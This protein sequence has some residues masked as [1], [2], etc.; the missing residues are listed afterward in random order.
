MVGGIRYDCWFIGTHFIT[1][2][3]PVILH[4]V[5]KDCLLLQ[6]GFGRGGG[7][8]GRGSSSG[9]GSRGGSMT[10]ETGHW[11]E[12]PVDDA[13]VENRLRGFGRGRTLRASK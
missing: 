3:L 5:L 8:F 7:G 9:F 4:G 12:V 6:G 2:I 10:T 11:G 13:P 1:L